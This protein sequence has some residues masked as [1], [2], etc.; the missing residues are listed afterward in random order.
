MKSERVVHS[1]HGM[2]FP[3]MLARTA[4]LATVRRLLLNLPAV[5]VVGHHR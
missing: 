4:H 1:F 2:R 3:S 5:D